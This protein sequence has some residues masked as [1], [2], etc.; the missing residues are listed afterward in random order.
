MTEKEE[1]NEFEKKLIEQIENA[2]NSD[3]NFSNSKP[4]E[5]AKEIFGF[6]GFKENGQKD[7]IDYVLKKKGNAMG[8]IPTGGGKSACFQI[9]ALIQENMTIVVSPLIALMKDQVEN[10]VNKGIHSAFFI[11]SSINDDV[12][13]KILD[14]ITKEKIKLLY[15]APE[16]LQSE[17]I[18][19]ILSKVKIDLIVIDEAHCISTW[20]HNFRPDYLKLAQIIDDLGSPEVLALTATATK[21]VMLD[22]Q[23]QLKRKFK[24]FKASFDRPNLYLVVQNVPDNI[25][26]EAFL[27]NL[28]KQ[29]KGPTVI[30]ART[31]ELTENIADLFNKNGIKSLFYHAGLSSE[32]REKRQ[33][34]FMKSECDIIVATIAFGMGIDKKNIRNVIHYNVPQSVEGYY[35]EIGRAGRDGDKSNCILLYTEGD[36]NRIKALIAAD[37]PDKTKIQ[38][39]ITHLKNKSTNMIFAHPKSLEYETEI[40]EIPIRLIL[41]RLEEAGAIKKYSSVLNNAKVRFNKNYANIINSVDD[42]YK[43]DTIKIFSS[44]YFKNKRSIVNFEVLIEETKLNYFRILEIFRY[45]AE[46]KFIEILREHHKDLIMVNRKLDSFDISPLVNLFQDILNKNYQKVDDLVNCLCSNDCIRKNVLSYFDEPDLKDNCEMCSNCITYD[47]IDKI[48]MK[49][50]ENFATDEEIESLSDIKVDIDND[51]LHITLLKVIAIDKYIPKKDFVKILKGDLH[52]FSA[53][54]K[55]KLE[56][57]ELLID[58]EESEIENTLNKLI[59]DNLVQVTAEGILRIGKKGIEYLGKDN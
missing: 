2:H 57:Y 56:S 16:S 54:W 39:L 21:K 45:L 49:V 13:E 52:R 23:K 33:N 28:M 53:R 42:K 51:E 27:L 34:R 41:H 19:N 7:I 37:W 26:K 17:R 10:L 29:L 43:E 36:I 46:M 15:I 58:E 32:E 1:F 55:F 18:I 8:I 20:G 24:V 4:I 35:Q 5:V 30:F 48:P 14:L 59:S 47:V 25:D 6:N 38:D 22:I 44:E 9:P 11:N 40:K 50:N 3:V 12:K 31:R